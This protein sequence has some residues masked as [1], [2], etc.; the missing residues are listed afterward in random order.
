M[1][2]SSIPISSEEKDNPVLFIYREWKLNTNNACVLIVPF[3]FSAFFLS[4]SYFLSILFYTWWQVGIF[5]ATFNTTTVH[6]KIIEDTE[7]VIK[8]CKLRK[9]NNAIANRTRTN[10]D[11]YNITHNTRLSNTNSRKVKQFLLH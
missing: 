1:A 6:G 4:N 10:N 7:G 3:G 11:L 8:S 2:G 5:T 9:T